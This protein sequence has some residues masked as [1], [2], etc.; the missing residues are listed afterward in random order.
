MP[1]INETIWRESRKAK[2]FLFIYTPPVVFAASVN[3]TTF[4]YPMAQVTFDNVTEGAYTDLKLGQLVKFMDSSGNFKQWGRVRKTPTSTILYFGHMSEGELSV[5]DNDLI[6]VYD[7]YRLQAKIPFITNRGVEYKDFD[8]AWSDET[9]DIPPKCNAG[10]FTSKFVDSLD[11]LSVDFDLTNSY[12]VA[13]GA[14]ISSYAGD[15]G[16]GTVTSGSIASGVFTAE[17]PVGTRWCY[18]TVTDSNTKT[19]TMKVLVNAAHPED[20]PPTPCAINSFD[21]DRE[22]GSMTFRALTDFQNAAEIMPGALVIFWQE[23]TYGEDVVSL[24]NYPDREHVKFVG[25]LSEDSISIDPKTDTIVFTALSAT[26]IM[27]E[28]PSFPTR[29]TQKASPTKWAQVRNLSLFRFLHYHLHWHSTA[30][31]LCDLEFPE[32][33]STY[34]ELAQLDADRTDLFQ[35]ILGRAKAVTAYF[36]SDYNGRLYF[37]RNPQLVSDAVRATFDT[38]VTLNEND[39]NFIGF[40]ERHQQQTYWL[41]GSAIQALYKKVVPFL[42]ISPGT[43]PGQ[44]RSE[45]TLDRQLVADQADLNVRTGRQYTL[46]NAD[47]K[48][49]RIAVFRAGQIVCPGLLEYVNVNLGTQY[50][51][52]QRGFSDQKFIPVRVSVRFEEDGTNSEEWELEPELYGVSALRQAVPVERRN[53]P[54]YGA[55]KFTPISLP[56]FTPINTPTG[57]PGTIYAATLDGMYR[58]FNYADFSSANWELMF[59]VTDIDPLASII[60]DIKFDPHNAMRGAYATVFYQSGDTGMGLFYIDNMTGPAGTQTFTNIFKTQEDFVG[61]VGTVPSAGG[62]IHASINVPGMLFLTYETFNIPVNE[63]YVFYRHGYDDDF[64]I[65]YLNTYDAGYG[66]VQIGI[67]THASSPTS[68]DVYVAVNDSGT[69]KIH[70]VTNN[71]GAVSGGNLDETITASPLNLVSILVPYVE[72]GDDELL[73]VSSFNGDYSLGLLRRDTGGA[74]TDVA[75]VDSGF[76]YIQG[77]VHVFTGSP[78]Y[79]VGR[80]REL[81][82][83]SV[84]NFRSTDGGDTWELITAPGSETGHS[85]MGYLLAGHPSDANFMMTYVKSGAN[86]GFWVSSN[87]F[88]V[89]AGSV[90]W[91]N[92]LG[93]F[94]TIG[95]DVSL[96]TGLTPVYA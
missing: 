61:D 8:D 51:K 70:K 1:P 77:V 37:R 73:F 43:T 20:N 27:A 16:D 48:N 79:V 69:I 5:E 80:L 24:G 46:E 21:F 60:T 86:R 65:D 59:S 32:W 96:L 93:D 84:Q 88:S 12:A 55:I 50:N 68:G 90:T 44:G 7:D 91:D 17:F 52:R 66:G 39:Y 58:T 74:Y 36:S 71:T 83:G 25:W 3:Q 23:E 78:D 31:E 87:I 95:G 34:A 54:N 94:E 53:D 85:V 13:F 81:D 11:V 63:S 40:S 62:V 72:G 49:A 89:A 29:L 82:G 33:N 45:S 75:P 22:G 10:P 42:A 28:L 56:E 35:Q 15:I 41:R 38:T 30:L 19:H 67:G 18:F 4:V 76:T 92:F 64:T 9:D 2:G 14:T 57:A 26:R 6:E 47:I